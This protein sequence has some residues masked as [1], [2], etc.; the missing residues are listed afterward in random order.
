MALTPGVDSSFQN[1]HTGH[2]SSIYSV[3]F[4]LGGKK[5]MSGSHD[6]TVQIWDAETGLQIDNTLEV[7]TEWVHSVTVSLDGK[8]ITSASCN[9]YV[10]LMDIDSGQLVCAELEGHASWVFSVAFLPDSQ[11]VISGSADTTIHIWDVNSGSQ[12]SVPFAPR[13]QGFI[14]LVAFSPDGIQILVYKWAS[15]SKAIRMPYIVHSRLMESGWCLAQLTVSFTSGTQK[16]DH[17]WAILLVIE[18]SFM[19]SPD[20]K[21][22]VS[23][24]G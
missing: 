24:S 6:H 17:K 9:N 5:I 19:F 20:G 7:H 13:F 8:L 4:S 15:H 12:I 21:L 2:F 16:Q 10:C 23:A 22:V 14:Y 3:A 18:K 11:Q 1:G